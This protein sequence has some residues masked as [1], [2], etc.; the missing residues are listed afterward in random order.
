[1]DNSALLTLLQIADSGF[2]T[3]G[4][5]FSHG[6]EGLVVGGFVRDAD[7]IAKLLQVQIEENLAGIELPAMRHAYRCAVAGDLDALL[8]LDDLLT[9]LKPVPSA[10]AASVK[11]GHRLLVSAAGLMSDPAL[12]AY[13]AAIDQGHGRGHHAAA[14]GVVFAA[15]GIDEE[16]AALTLGAISLQGWTAAAVRL[17]VIGQAAA[18]GIIAALRPAVQSAV[19]ASRSQ[20]LDDMGASTPMLDIAGLRQPNLVGRLF[21]S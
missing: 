13:L 6:I 12:D 10:R 7:D 3:G 4:Y 14:S 19:E 8:V 2:P 18:Q 21:A 1:V 15:I 20:Q 11:V 16:T 9:A 5:A 17:G